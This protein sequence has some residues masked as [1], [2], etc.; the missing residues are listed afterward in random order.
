ML[1]GNSCSEASEVFHTVAQG[2]GA[3]H[4]P[5]IVL[6]FLIFSHLMFLYPFTTI[7]DTKIVLVKGNACVCKSP[8]FNVFL[9]ILIE[10]SLPLFHFYFETSQSPVSTMSC[11][12]CSFFP[13][14]PIHPPL[15]FLLYPPSFKKIP[16]TSSVNTS[17]LQRMNCASALHP[18]KQLAEYASCYF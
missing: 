7:S 12:N 13:P 2:L 6:V 16:S 3:S 18:L 1:Q 15:K 11:Y 4:F 9:L 8:V 10:I 14:I 17:K 5:L